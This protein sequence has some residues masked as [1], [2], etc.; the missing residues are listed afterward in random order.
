M[1]GKEEEAALLGFR[2]LSRAPRACR[3]CMKRVCLFSWPVA[4]WAKT[5]LQA[6]GCRSHPRP[7]P[8]P[9]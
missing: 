8:C 2:P 7:T 3:E 1:V 5:L 6:L 9:A 4:L